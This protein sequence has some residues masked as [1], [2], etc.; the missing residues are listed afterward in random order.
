MKTLKQLKRP[1]TTVRLK[2][3]KPKKNPSGGAA[4]LS[5]IV[6]TKEQDKSSTKLG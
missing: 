6:V 3:I 4:S 5:D 2:D 1:K